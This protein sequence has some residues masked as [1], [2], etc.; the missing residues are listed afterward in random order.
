MDAWR[1]LE[2]R[3]ARSLLLTRGLL[4][5]DHVTHRLLLEALAAEGVEMDEVGASEVANYFP[6]LRPDGRDAVWEPGASLVKASDSLDAHRM[7]FEAANGALRCSTVREVQ[8]RSNGCRVILEAGRP[9]DV[10]VVVLAPGAGASPLL[11]SVGVD[12]PLRPSLQQI[13][14]FRDEERASRFDDL[15]VLFDG[16]SGIEPAFYT[17]PTPGYG[18]K[19]GLDREIRALANG[20]VDRSPNGRLVS[21]TVKRVQRMLPGI[22]GSVFDVQTCTWTD[23]PDGRFIIDRLPSGVVVACGDSGEGFKFSALFGTLL[24]DLAEGHSADSDLA[25]FGI[26]RFTNGVATTERHAVGR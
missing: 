14:H 20:D 2:S 15:P 16:R 6:G 9:L 7:I 22:G 12:I 26:G 19:A 8:V 5:R 13:V 3:T 10:D 21:E 23:S 17:M 11:T 4:W 18:L 24:A 25:A 1:A